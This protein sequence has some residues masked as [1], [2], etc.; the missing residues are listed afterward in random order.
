[1]ADLLALSAHLPEITLAAGD[2][3]VHEGDTGGSVWV[4][5]DGAL[6]VRKSGVSINTITHPGSLIGEVSVLLGSRA[7]ATVVATGPCRLRHAA[8]GKA[9][10]S[11]DS[12][13]TTLVAAGLAERLDFVNTYL[14]DLKQQYGDA[15]GLAMVSDVL[16]KLSQRTGPTARPGSARE[17]NPEY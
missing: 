16:S 11:S 14:A 13:I 8:D 7:K 9:F 1:V 5:V 2:V 15:P 10:L 17:P 6:E 3:V 12:A 4:L